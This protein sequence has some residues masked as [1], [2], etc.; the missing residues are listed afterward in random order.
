V[1][2]YFTGLLE[3]GGLSLPQWVQMDFC[4]H[5]GFDDATALM[6]SGKEYVNL[7]PALQDAYTA[8]TT[9]PVIGSFHFVADLPALLIIVLITALIYRDERVVMQVI[10]WWCQIVYRSFSDCC[11]CF[12][13]R[14]C[15]LGSICSKW[16]LEF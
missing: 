10:S 14:Y 7:S 11:W 12:L 9:S 8:W 15:K 16:L 5:L 1:S 13:C 4:L 3:S 2:D 6:Q